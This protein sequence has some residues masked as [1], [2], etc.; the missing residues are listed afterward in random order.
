MLR[1][2]GLLYV[3][4][5]NDATFT[6]PEPILRMVEAHDH[7]YPGDRTILTELPRRAREFGLELEDRHVT[8]VR[9]TGGPEPVLV[10]DEILLGVREGW[11]LLAFMRAQEA[12]ARLFDEAQEHYFRTGCEISVSIETHVYRKPPGHHR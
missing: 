4:D 9:N 8:T 3:V 1:P 10:R 6:G 5:V 7:H 2:G 12:S 11:G